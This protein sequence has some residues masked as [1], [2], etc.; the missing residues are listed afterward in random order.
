MSTDQDRLI[1]QTRAY[2]VVNA[3]WTLRVPPEVLVRCPVQDRLWLI[4]MAIAGITAL[5]G[6]TLVSHPLSHGGVTRVSHRC[7]IDATV[8][9]IWGQHGPAFSADSRVPRQP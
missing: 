2:R 6:V 4:G 9:A 3:K 7:H 5:A 8:Q 1:P